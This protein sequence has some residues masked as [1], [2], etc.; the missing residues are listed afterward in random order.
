MDRQLMFST[1]GTKKTFN[2]LFDSDEFSNSTF[3]CL[4][5]THTFPMLWLFPF[6]SAIFSLSLMF[7]YSRFLFFLLVRSFSVY[8]L[9]MFDSLI[10]LQFVLP[11]KQEQK[12]HEQNYEKR[13]KIQ[14][15]ANGIPRERFFCILFSSI[16]LFSM[17]EKKKHYFL[18]DEYAFN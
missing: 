1:E 13:L 10:P 14:N 11:L 18:S 16:Y 7:F 6:Q 2:S 17:E 8:I 12:K 5:H 4:A 3:F 9:F 15:K